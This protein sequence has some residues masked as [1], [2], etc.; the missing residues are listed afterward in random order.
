EALVG[1][2]QKFSVRSAGKQHIGR[3]VPDLA[4]NDIK[5]PLVL[6]ANIDD[7]KASSL[8][9][10]AQGDFG[11]PIK[12][13]V[14]DITLSA[15]HA[16]KQVS[17]SFRVGALRLIHELHNADHV[18]GAY[19]QISTELQDAVPFLK[20]GCTAVAVDMLENILS[21]RVDSKIVFDFREARRIRNEIRRVTR[22][23]IDID[24]SLTLVPATPQIELW[25]I[26][27]I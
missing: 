6:P 19:F 18:R 23:K 14:A 27:I 3:G 24:K 10:I 9:R 8:E 2:G 25:S 5:K 20:R 4:A 11:E 22:M 21:H 15:E 12:V 7:L 17:V 1:C 16:L 26:F 13:K